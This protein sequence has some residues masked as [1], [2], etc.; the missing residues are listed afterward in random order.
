ME[1][2]EIGSQVDLERLRSKITATYHLLDPD[3]P[4]DGRFIAKWR[5]RLNVSEDELHNAVRT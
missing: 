3:L 4:P 1:L 2:Y 5:L